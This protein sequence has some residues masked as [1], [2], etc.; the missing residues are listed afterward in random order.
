MK[1]QEFA[2][3]ETLTVTIEREIAHIKLS[4]PKELN[5]M[6]MA[7]WRE[8]P[9]V[10]KAI[11]YQAAARV[12]VI[13]ASGKHFTAGMDLSIFSNMETFFAGEPARRSEHFRRWVMTLQDAF[14]SLEQARMPVLAAV[15]GGC[16]GGGLDMICA[17]DCRY[18]TEDAFF[19]IKETQLGFHR[20]CGNAAAL[21]LPDTPWTST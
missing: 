3:L 19:T 10:V 18:C 16:I 11:D 6:N 21:T 14:T 4:R 8:L 7:F 5:A 9:A 17:A 15:Q 2:D 20:R 12:I 13:S 1:A